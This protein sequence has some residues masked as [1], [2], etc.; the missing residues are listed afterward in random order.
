MPDEREFTLRDAMKGNTHWDSEESVSYEVAL[1]AV[2][3]AVGAFSGRIHLEKKRASP[4]RDILEK[5]DGN[6][7]WCIRQRQV[8]EP[9]DR[10]QIAAARQYFSE[11]TRRV[12]EGG[13]IEVDESWWQ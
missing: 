1:E 11:L 8:L 6:R 9:T 2:N 3:A 13:S 4:D 12:R 7:G 5:L 10:R